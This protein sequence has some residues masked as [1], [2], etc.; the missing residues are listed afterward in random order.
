MEGQEVRMLIDEILKKHPTS[1][2]P[3]GI[4]KI[5]NVTD[6]MLRFNDHKG[7]ELLEAK[8]P[9][10]YTWFEYRWKTSDQDK[11]MGIYCF[12]KNEHDI[13][14][15]MIAVYAKMLDKMFFVGHSRHLLDKLGQPTT[16]R[17]TQ[18]YE[19]SVAITYNEKEKQSMVNFMSSQVAVI[20]F[21]L[22]L[23]SCKNVERIDNRFDAKL[24]KA[25]QKRNKPYF[26]KY[27]TLA[28][29]PMKKILESEGEA[30][31]KGIQHALHICR[32]HFKTYEG[33]GL[34]GK[35]KGR[36][37]WPSQVRGDASIG[38][39]HKDYEVKI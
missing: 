5:Q 6:Y 35:Y 32:G 37:W 27:Y 23:L 13:S 38:K 25:W 21:T 18:V 11:H 7:I 1:K 31:I 3:D 33:K 34:F 14:Y 19:T 30:Q 9:F 20:Y 39:I 10:P 29:E 8:I 17:E 22:N 2:R 16:I 4:F 28:I 15:L 12:I 36:F 24:I 26:E